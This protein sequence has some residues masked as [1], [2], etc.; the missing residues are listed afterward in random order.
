MLSPTL[1]LNCHYTNTQHCTSPTIA[2]VTWTLQ[3]FVIQTTIRNKMPPSSFIIMCL[4]LLSP[5]LTF[6][7]YLVIGAKQNKTHLLFEADAIS[8][9]SELPIT[10]L[11]ALPEAS[12]FSFCKL[13]LSLSRD[14][15]KLMCVLET[16]A[17]WHQGLKEASLHCVETMDSAPHG[18]LT[19]N[20]TC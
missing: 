15:H 20:Q 9:P 5:P 6:T 1:E 17:R 10:G 11:C 13:L 18:S 12:P 3:Y 4:L 8:S 2:R 19:S 7:E 16:G 14:K